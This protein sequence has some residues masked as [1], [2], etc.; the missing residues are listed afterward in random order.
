MAIPIVENTAT[1]TYGAVAS[2]TFPKTCTGSNLLLEVAVQL[3]NV[4]VLDKSVTGITYNGVAL[5][6]VR[7]D[8]QGGGNVA[9]EVWILVAPATGGAFDVVVN[10]NIAGNVGGVV[11][12]R[13]ITGARQSAQ[14][15]ANN[16]AS[17]ATLA[18]T[19]TV[20]TVAS[21]C[22][23]LDSLAWFF[24]GADDGIPG[25]GQ[26]EQFDLSSA[27]SAHGAGSS[28][29]AASPGA[30]TMS[31][32]IGDATGWAL[33]AVSYAPSTVFG[34]SRNPQSLLRRKM[35]RNQ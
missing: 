21:D 6:F 5:T 23:V 26:T 32:T 8:I 28:E 19:V 18:P 30:V 33:A 16:G 24:L 20:T 34:S 7:R 31:W 12:A 2:V 11:A 10:F 1:A 13:S 27:T 3:R 35:W 22:I 9:S 4:P 17:G 25:A 14:P 29:G 15:D